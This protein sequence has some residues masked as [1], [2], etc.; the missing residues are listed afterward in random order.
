[1]PGDPQGARGKET[2]GIKAAQKAASPDVGPGSWRTALPEE[3]G[4]HSEPGTERRLGK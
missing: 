2:R 4:G 1:M 3:C